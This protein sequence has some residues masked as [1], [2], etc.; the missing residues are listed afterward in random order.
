MLRRLLKNKK[1][2]FTIIGFLPLTVSVVFT[3]VY[4]NYL[5]L[6][7]Y[8]FLNFYN[9]FLG[10]IA[11][12]LHI[13]IKDGFGF[14][15]W[16]NTETKVQTDQFFNNSFSTMLLFQ[17]AT[18][19]LF[20][21]LGAKVLPMWF[22]AWAQPEYTSYI[23]VAAFYAFFLNF[24]EL[25]FYYYRNTNEIRKFVQLNVASLLLMT[26]GSFLGIFVFK[27]GLYGAI[28]GKFAGYALVV[29]YFFIRQIRFLTWNPRP[30]FIRQIISSGF[31][32]LVG[33]VLGAYS[34]VCDKY[35]LQEHFSISTLGVYGMALTIVYLVEILLTSF[36]HQMLPATLKKIQ[37]KAG[38][39]VIVPPIK[40][41]FHLMALF[42][43][44]VMAATPLVLKLFPPDYQTVMLYVPY[45]MLIPFIKFIYNFN[46]LNFYLFSA[47]RV[48]LKAQIIS[49]VCTFL[50]TFLMPPVTLI[51]GAVVIALCYNL[52]QLLISYLF[53]VR[54]RYFLLNNRALWFFLVLAVTLLIAVGV[55]YHVTGYSILFFVPFFIYSVVVLKGD[56]DFFNKFKQS[57]Q[58]APRQ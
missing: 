25:F 14:L 54:E 42:G 9:T 18:M 50:I 55:G 19:A 57:L 49:S 35:F 24:N 13:G 3:P 2:L 21:F 28:M 51:F 32:I 6:E 48:F 56:P 37:E 15:Y 4:V 36:M 27:L 8:G 1:I 43:F 44:V 34:S 20:L 33:S 38:A 31:P 23:W 47:S 17:L 16:K 41:V 5:S 58:V 53:L 46:V 45:L 29:V 30:Q 22:E 26:L 40:D 52:F 12:V 10:I 11:P 39:D 7:D